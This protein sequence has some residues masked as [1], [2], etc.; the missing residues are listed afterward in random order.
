[1]DS[2]IFYY[3]IHTS[4]QYTGVKT[5]NA[6]KFGENISNHQFFRRLVTIQFIFIRQTTI[7]VEDLE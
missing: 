3:Q 5:H 1:M 6:L 4:P 2:L 7:S